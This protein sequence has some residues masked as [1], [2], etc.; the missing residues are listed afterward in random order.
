MTWQTSR[1]ILKIKSP[2]S[3]VSLGSRPTIPLVRSPSLWRQPRAL[4]RIRKSPVRIPLA[5]PPPMNPV[6][7]PA[8][9]PAAS[10]TPLS[11]YRFRSERPAPKSDLARASRLRIS[12]LISMTC[13]RPAG[14]TVKA[15][16]YL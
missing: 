10:V 14:L 7:E 9:F 16:G 4:E 15:L 8:S 12:V 3:P 11:L 6:G 5:P 13:V 1:V 2:I